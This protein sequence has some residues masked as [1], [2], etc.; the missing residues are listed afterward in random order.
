MT[1]PHVS[2]TLIIRKSCSAPPPFPQ[3]CGNRSN[4]SKVTPVTSRSRR[5]AGTDPTLQKNVSNPSKKT[6]QKP[7]PQNCG[8][9]PTL[10]QKV[11]PVTSRSRKIAG[12]DPTLQKKNPS[13]TPP[14]KIEGTFQPFS[15]KS[16]PSR[17]VPAKLRERIQPFKKKNLQK[18]TS[19]TLPSKIEGT[20]PT[21]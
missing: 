18:N 2:S 1:I 21:L 7:F 15:K 8:T 5:I 19:E 12:T 11:T 10:Q 6:H 16:H 20:I 4:P 14:S 17:H 3:K 9:E 13:K